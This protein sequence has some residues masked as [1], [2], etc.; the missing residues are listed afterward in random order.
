[1]DVNSLLLSLLFNLSSTFLTL[2]IAIY[3]TLYFSFYRNLEKRRDE[4][5]I[6]AIDSWDK[7]YKSFRNLID[8]V[9]V[10]YIRILVKKKKYESRYFRIIQ[11]IYYFTSIVLIIFSSIL[12]TFKNTAFFYSSTCFSILSFLITIYMSYYEWLFYKLLDQLDDIE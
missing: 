1:M 6:K 2:Y 11:F 12:E 10:K 9:Q 3:I 4:I 7:K 5:R 8:N